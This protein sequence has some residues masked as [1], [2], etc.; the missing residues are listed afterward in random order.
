MQQVERKRVAAHQIVIDDERPDQVVAAQHVEGLGHLGAL[1]KAAFDHFLLEAIELSLVDEH[2]QLARIREVGQRGHERPADDA[3]VLLHRHVG[4]HC[5]E[6]RSAQTVADRVDFLFAG[7]FLDRIERSQRS[8]LQVAGEVLFGMA[9]VRIDPGDHEYGE[10]LIHHPFDERIFLAQI[11]DVVLVD[12]GWN[13]EQRPLGDLGR[14]RVVLDQLHEF[15]LEH[16]LARGGRDVDTEFERL[17]IGHRDLQLAVAALDVVEQIV[18]ALDQVPAA[19]RDRLAEHFGIRDGEVRRRHRVD[20]LAGEERD[21]LLG[22]GREALDVGHRLL[23]PA[24]GNQVGLLDVVEQ[25]MFL[26]I[27]VLEALVAFGR[28]DDGIHRRAQHFERRR[29]PQVHVVPPQR[30]LRFGE[31][32]GV[33]HHLGGQFV[34]RFGDAELVG[35]HGFAGRG[36]A[37]NDIA[38]Q[39]RA[40]VGGRGERLG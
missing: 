19:G 5:G 8:F 12:P 1:E 4:E 36:L 29:L 10:P 16:H 40:L 23:Q 35:H 31:P 14:G 9:L 6:Q 7:C 2:P 33:R 18:Q 24:R 28:L 39:L 34:K 20:V 3:L 17:R 11:E 13:D 37:G 15:V 26:P 21:L 32:V 22:L 30:H 25:R 38:K 27:V